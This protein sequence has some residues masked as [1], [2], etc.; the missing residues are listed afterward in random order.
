MASTFTYGGVT[1][2]TYGLYVGEGDDPWMPTPSVQI[3]GSPVGGYRFG[4]QGYAPGE[5]VLPCYVVGVDASTYASYRDS[6]ARTLDV[7]NGAKK[8]SIEAI[9]NRYWLAILKSGMAPP[10]YA[11]YDTL[12]D[13]TFALEGYGY[14]TTPVTAS[15]TINASPYSFN[16]SAP[17]GSAPATVTW[18]VRNTT[19][20]T[21]TTAFK[22][23]STTIGE[24]IEWQGSLTTGYWIRVGHV[25]SD[26]RYIYSLGVSTA[27]GA[28]PT[29]L[30]YTDSK[31]G[32][33]A[34]GGDWPRLKAGATN[35]IQITGLTAGTVQYA[36][37]PR[38][39][40]A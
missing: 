1:L 33:T 8:L 31:S 38:Y 21:V 9:P 36:Y 16:I 12:F 32:V 39:I 7:T 29:V 27:S 24:Y 26:G 6:I 11:G 28:D 37:T 2:S 13:L 17:A 34:N 5:V 23:N 30:T 40:G 22:I 20:A 19:G 18:Y 35:A 10:H 3:A 15:D 14:D 4:G 25:D